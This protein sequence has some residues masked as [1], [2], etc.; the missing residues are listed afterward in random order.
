MP[1]FHN[2]SF[3]IFFT[4]I[5][6][7]SFSQEVNDSTTYMVVDNILIE[8]NKKTKNSI[9][10]RELNFKEGDTIFIQ[11]KEEVFK[12]SK[13]RIFNTNLFVTVNLHTIDRDSIHKDIFIV[14]KE[15]WYIY[16][17][18]IFE[19]ADRNFN[20]WWQDRNRDPER[21]NVG[22]HYVQKNVRG[23][24]ETLRL[25]FQLG[26]TKKFELFYFIPYLN[27]KQ[28]SGLNYEISFIRNKQIP[29]ITSENKLLYFDGNKIIKERF[30]T[31]FTYTYRKKFYQT[32]SIGSGFFY[33]WIADTIRNLNPHYLLNDRT[34]Q[35]YFTLKYTFLNDVR[36]VAYYPLKGTYVKA[37]VEKLGLG[38]FNDLNQINLT[39]EFSWF[40]PLSKKLFLATGIRQKISF[41]RR[42]P[43]LQT[44]ALG[45]EKDY[46]S[47]YELYVI[48]GE[49]FSLAKANLKWKIF[50]TQK[51]LQSVPVDEFSTIPFA[52]YLKIYSDMGYV[53]NQYTL[54][55]NE[56]LTNTFLLGGGLG[57]DIV[58]YYDFV[59]RLEYSINRTGEHGFFLHFRS[60]I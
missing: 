9:I 8:G 58:S 43:Y 21:I 59:M 44:R 15:R 28:K 16:P 25:K 49:H 34:S 3:F 52:L 5:I 60:E 27:K 22:L 6:S 14:V 45:Y 19:L 32:H 10:L 2:L 38:I 30:R 47:G 13:N 11:E 17:L 57:L 46:V 7:P 20:E 50:S 56:R 1:F 35:R 53:W 4:L 31:A 54:P 12:W 39:G 36:D 24:N 18:P 51:D 48:D 29:F 55:D 40:K 37:E 33:N 23:R 26:F 42:Q 41:P